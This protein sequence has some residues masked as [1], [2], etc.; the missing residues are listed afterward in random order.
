MNSGTDVISSA[1]TSTITPDVL[2]NIPQTALTGP[3]TASDAAYSMMTSNV[4]AIALVSAVTIGATAYTTYKVAK[5]IG[6]KYD[7][8][9]EE[10][11]RSH[12]DAIQKLYRDHLQGIRINGHEVFS[13]VFDIKDEKVEKGKQIKVDAIH[14]TE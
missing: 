2:T 12:I 11:F 4:G 9:I 7:I 3:R 13:P 5:Y 8:Y 10:G 1:V 6:K 14:F